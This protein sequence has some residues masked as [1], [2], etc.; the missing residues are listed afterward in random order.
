M[1]LRQWQQR[2]AVL[3]VFFR[4]QEAGRRHGTERPGRRRSSENKLPSTTAS[5]SGI[6]SGDM[7]R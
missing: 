1:K 5:L 3:K 2:D 7:C 6:Y 4:A